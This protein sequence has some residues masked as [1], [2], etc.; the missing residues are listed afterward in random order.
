M[1]HMSVSATLLTV[2]HA[3]NA[4]S[5]SL[6]SGKSPR[7]QSVSRAHTPRSPIST[8]PN[9]QFFRFI[10]RAEEGSEGSAQGTSNVA[11]QTASA[12][13]T[14]EPQPASGNMAVAL[15]SVA[16]GVALFLVAR[17]GGGPVGLE[18]LAANAVPLDTAL[19]NGRPT[20]MEFYADWCE[21][22]RESA[23]TIF[24]LE[25]KYGSDVNFVMLNIDNNKWTPEI[26]EYGVGGIPHFVFLDNSGSELATVIGR[27]PVEVLD[28]NTA[29]LIESKPLPFTKSRGE[30][31]S[32]NGTPS[33]SM[34]G[35]TDPRAHG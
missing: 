35:P 21:V 19:S 29:A 17:L 3:R 18:Q 26:T 22:C 9:R 24:S 27:L 30:T 33:S 2:P 5:K 1:P 6:A 13:K 23:P 20:V 14:P 12:P 16:A 31:S 32:M 10:C 11:T 7:K 25:Q 15:G 8:C 4:A 28:G 34:K